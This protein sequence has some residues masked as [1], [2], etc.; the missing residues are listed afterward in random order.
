MRTNKYVSIFCWNLGYLLT[1]E[2]YNCAENERNNITRFKNR[3]SLDLLYNHRC[4]N[5]LSVITF[6]PFRRS[7]RAVQKPIPFAPPVTS[8]ILPSMFMIDRWQRNERYPVLFLSRYDGGSRGV[9]A[10]NLANRIYLG[11]WFLR[12][13]VTTVTD[14]TREIENQSYRDRVSF[15]VI[16]RVMWPR[17][18]G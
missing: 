4:N 15:V 6:A 2:K 16:W 11:G 13:Q 8:A 3:N 17:I 18:C 5:L 12:R 1:L 9:H 14:E 7:F 10:R